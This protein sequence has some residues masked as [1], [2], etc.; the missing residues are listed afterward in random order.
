MHRLCKALVKGMAVATQKKI[1]VVDDE[2]DIV[3]LIAYNL[4]Q[5]GFAVS[6]AYDGPAAWEKVRTLKPDLAVLD[7]MLPGMSGLE[8]CKLIRRHAETESLPVIMLTAKSDPVDKI[9]GL[10][11]GADDYITKPFSLR[12]LV[13][14]I[15]AVLRRS[16]AHK[17]SN[18]PAETFT[19]P[20]LEIDFASCTVSVDKERVPLS[21]RE[22]KLLQF[23]TRRPGRVYSREQLLEQVWGDETF[24]EPRTVDV[25]ISR[26]RA[27]IEKDKE[28]P[29]YILT[30]R[31][32]GYKF[33]DITPGRSA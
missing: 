23:L 9:L 7:L 21:S 19:C 8:V 2:K 24:V 25:H 31:G 5:E 6:C 18:V 17:E 30:V 4:E 27:A 15:R 28:H 12:E 32:L 10:E 26:L 16:R 33:A 13:A 22:F 1:L 3:E 14:R 29:R 20:G 11:L